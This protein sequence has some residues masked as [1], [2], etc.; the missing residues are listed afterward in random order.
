[1]VFEKSYQRTVL[2]SGKQVASLFHAGFLLGLF[3]KPEDGSEI[4]LRNVI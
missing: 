2:S 3:F 1:M 4:I